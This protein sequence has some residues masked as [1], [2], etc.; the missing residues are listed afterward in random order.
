M[1]RAVDSK[2]H[3]SSAERAE[4]KFPSI[5]HRKKVFSWED[6]AHSFHPACGSSFFS[7]ENVENGENKEI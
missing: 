5:Y 3:S 2:I 1:F 4:E 6:L 7:P